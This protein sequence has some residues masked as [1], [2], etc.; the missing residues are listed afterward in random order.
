MTKM[1]EMTVQEKH[2]LLT[3]RQWLEIEVLALVGEFERATGWLVVE[4][5]PQSNLTDFDGYTI[6][7]SKEQG[8]GFY[9]SAVQIEVKEA[10]PATLLG[11]TQ[12]GKLIPL[13]EDDLLLEPLTLHEDGRFER[14]EESD[15]SEIPF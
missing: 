6:P 1:M 11:T 10:S 15:G 4:I 3:Q 5:R 14:E 9:T 13:E 8:P 7:Y 2:L 12:R